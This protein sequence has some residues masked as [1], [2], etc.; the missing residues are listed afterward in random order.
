MHTPVICSH[1]TTSTDNTRYCLVRLVLRKP[2]QWH[3]ISTLQKYEKEI[4]DNGLLAALSDLCRPINCP[5]HTSEPNDSF[6]KHEFTVADV[7][8]KAEEDSREII[9][10]TF[11]TEEEQDLKPVQGEYLQPTCTYNAEAGASHLPT[12]ADPVKAVLQSNPAE[13]NLGFFCEDESQMTLED[14]LWRLSRD[15]LL[16]L[17]KSTRCRLPSRCKVP[18]ISNFVLTAFRFAD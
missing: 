2:N 1:R 5:M 12:L 6:V 15:Q 8:I 3:A 10:L 16:D 11:D 17:V 7:L 18:L 9:N 14:I 4:G 13:M